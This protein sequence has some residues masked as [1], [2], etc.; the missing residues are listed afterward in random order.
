IYYIKNHS[1]FPSIFITE[2]KDDFSDLTNSKK[3]HKDLENLF[4][5]NKMRYFTNIGEALNNIETN[6]I[7]DYIVKEIEDR[8][9]QTTCYRCGAILT[10]TG[11]WRQSQYGG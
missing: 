9:N 3:V 8:N 11:A 2:N 10:D 5:D 4:T 6:A 7:S 1:L